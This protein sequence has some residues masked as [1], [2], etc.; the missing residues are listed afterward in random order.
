MNTYISAIGYS[1]KLAGVHDPTKIFYVIQMLR[2]YSKVGF[3]LDTRLP[4]TLPILHQLLRAAPVVAETSYEAI[5]FKAMCALAFFAFLRVGEMTVTGNVSNTLQ[6][7]NLSKVYDH[8][9]HVISFKLN[10]GDFKHNY[11][12]RPFS[13]TIDRHSEGC[14]VQLLLDYFQLRGP[15]E[16]PLF[17]TSAG[18][19]VTRERFTSLLNAAISYCGLNPTCYKGHSF[20]IGAASHAAEKGM[21]D[22]QIR[23]MGRWRSN[24]FQKYIRIG[25]M[26]SHAPN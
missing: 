4:I 3:R 20:R 14:P 9:G 6:L 7:C 11:N 22:A 19:G 12:Q 13:L 23:V 1:H 26:A 2:G 8:S 25:S 5:L 21:T 17:I 24:A 16:G 15:S 18:V 10:F